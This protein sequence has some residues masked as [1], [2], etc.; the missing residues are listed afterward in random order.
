LLGQPRNFRKIHNTIALKRLVLNSLHLFAS[1]NTFTHQ[2][3]SE[4]I[5]RV[6]QSWHRLTPLLQKL[7][8][9]GSKQLTEPFVTFVVEM[10]WYP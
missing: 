3:Q 1:G 7:H 10:E 4:G 9:D 5:N 2:Q 6:V 8:P